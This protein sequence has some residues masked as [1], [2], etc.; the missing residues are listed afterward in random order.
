MKNDGVR[1][2]TVPGKKGKEGDRER[3]DKFT[4]PYF[5]FLFFCEIKVDKQGK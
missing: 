1:S 4:C 5:F 2:V 3:A